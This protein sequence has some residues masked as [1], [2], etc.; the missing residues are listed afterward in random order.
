MVGRPGDLEAFCRRE[1]PRLVGS[2]SL[3]CGDAAAA[4]DLAQEALARAVDRWDRVARMQAPGAWVHRVAINLANSHYRRRQ[5]ERRARTRHGAA[6]DHD[7][8]DL[9]GALAVREAVSRLPAKQRTAVTLRFFAQMSVA[10][11]A[12][13]MG[14][15]EGAVAQHTRRGVAALR[16]RFRPRESQH[17]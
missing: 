14:C 6:P 9:A 3:H 1:Y 17:G 2:L 5:A 11:T 8:G 16:A 7:D 4:E 15:S 12:A 10:E 13:V